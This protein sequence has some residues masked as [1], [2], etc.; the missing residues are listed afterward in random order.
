MATVV[1]FNKQTNTSTSGLI[2]HK[3]NKTLSTLISSPAEKLTFHAS[4]WSMTF[5]E[6]WRHWWRHTIMPDCTKKEKGNLWRHNIINYPI[7]APY[8]IDVTGTINYLWCRTLTVNY[9]LLQKK[10]KLNKK[11]YKVV[12]CKKSGK[13]TT[14][15]P[16]VFVYWWRHIKRIGSKMRSSESSHRWKCGVTS[17]FF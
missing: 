14:N 8:T 4:C 17:Q 2:H 15:Y 10:Y 5:I 11:N 3:I 13:I 7:S 1:T 16:K 12:K 9:F 6:A